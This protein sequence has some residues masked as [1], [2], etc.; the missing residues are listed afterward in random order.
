MEKKDLEI[1][2]E[3]SAELYVHSVD[4]DLVPSKSMNVFYNEKME[5]NRDISNLALIAY[6]NLYNPEHLIVIDSMAA[7][8]IGSIRMLMECKNIKKMYIN[9][10]NSLAVELIHKNISLNKL[11]INN[12]QIEVSNKDAN[13]LFSELA[14]LEC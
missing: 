12:I 7:S 14:Q 13:L 6:N 2:K 1:I 4:R 9:D 3:G 10:L 8:G 5:L 11:D